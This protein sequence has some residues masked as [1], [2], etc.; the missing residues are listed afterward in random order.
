MEKENDFIILSLHMMPYIV[1]VRAPN[2]DCFAFV[3]KF[4]TLTQARLWE[5]RY[6]GFPDLEDVFIT[7]ENDN[8]FITNKKEDEEEDD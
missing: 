1:W 4:T 7:M 5:G 2:G 8:E 3:R 6:S